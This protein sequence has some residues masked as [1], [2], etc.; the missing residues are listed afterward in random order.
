MN[1]KKYF[2]TGQVI[3]F[4]SFFLAAL[5][6]RLSLPATPPFFKVSPRL[7]GAI[8]KWNRY[9]RLFSPSRQDDST[10]I[11]TPSPPVVVEPRKRRISQ[12]SGVIRFS[13]ETSGCLWVTPKRRRK[14]TKW[15]YGR[16]RATS[17]STSRTSGSSGCHP[18]GPIGEWG[19][20]REC[21]ERE[22][23]GDNT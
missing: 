5:F 19:S 21:N 6:L 10:G 3:I 4:D 18:K 16:G 2:H 15:R 14:R 9:V 20:W 13:S 8:P 17:W 12:K 7:F 11:S 22:R 23:V 1:L